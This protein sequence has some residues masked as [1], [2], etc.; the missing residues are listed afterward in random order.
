M[1]LCEREDIEDKQIFLLGNTEIVKLREI[2][3]YIK[4]FFH[5]ES[6]IYSRDTDQKRYFTL[7]VTKAVQYGYISKEMKNIIDELCRLREREVL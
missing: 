3:S 2:L 7:D 4:E 6:I 1:L 5:S